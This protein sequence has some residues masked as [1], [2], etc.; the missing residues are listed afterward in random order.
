M[1]FRESFR[2][3]SAIAGVVVILPLVSLLSMPSRGAAASVAVLDNSRPPS[4]AAIAKKTTPVVV[5]ISTSSQRPAGVGS[6]GGRRLGHGDRQSVWL[7]TYGDGGNC[8]RQRTG[9]RRGAL[10]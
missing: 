9:H 8:Q 3:R 5:N 2:A 4:F 10:R 6:T 7:R 1:M